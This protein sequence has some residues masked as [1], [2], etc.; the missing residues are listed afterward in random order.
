MFQIDLNLPQHQYNIFIEAHLLNKISEIISHLFK[1]KKV[2]IITDSNVDEN[3]GSVVKANLIDGGFDVQFIVLKPGEES[4]SLQ[5]LECIY[6]KLLDYSANRDTLL[7]ALGGG[8]IGDITGFAAATF[9]RGIKYIQIP[10]SVIAQ[11]DSSIGG[12]VAVNLERGKNL[13]GSFYHP[14]AVLIDPEVLRSLEDRFFFDGMAEVIKYGLIKDS[15]LFNNLM[16]YK[17]K[18]EIMANIEYIIS[19]CCLIKKEIVEKDEKDIGERMLLNFGHTIGHGIEAYY[20]Y[21]TYTHGEAV[22]IGMYCISGIGEQ[23]GLTA[24][25]CNEKIKAILKQYH[26]PYK[27]PVNVDELLEIIKND[28]KVFDDGL[29]FILIKDIGNAYI[30]KVKLQDISIFLKKGAECN[31]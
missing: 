13:I 24:P 17:T 26:L 7:V 16:S 15:Q 5:S 14:H 27:A 22:A 10:T 12:K 25:G 6:N 31:E 30:N 28:K 21:K 18:E 29:N 19:T 8:V 3:Y 20:E 4:K 1:T 23:L 11:V 9:L 2:I